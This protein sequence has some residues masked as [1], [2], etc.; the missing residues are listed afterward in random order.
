MTMA[1]AKEAGQR[2]GKTWMQTLQE[3]SSTGAV[4]SLKHKVC[5]YVVMHV[6]RAQVCMHACTRA[7]VYMGERV[8][9][10]KQMY[11]YLDL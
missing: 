9:M 11:R 3:A 2:K 7:R 6:I 4:A 1:E 10:D 8:Y 5:V